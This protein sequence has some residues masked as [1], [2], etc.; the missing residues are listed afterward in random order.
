MFIIAIFVNIGMWFERFVIVV[1]SL[2]RDFLP[3]SWGYFSPTITDISILLGS[4][5]L[6]FTLT[7][8]F[9]RFL[10]SIAIAEIKAVSEGAQPTHHGEDHE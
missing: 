6:F 1:T 9:T 4:F 8:L 2:S 7:L 5:G 3:S 10:P